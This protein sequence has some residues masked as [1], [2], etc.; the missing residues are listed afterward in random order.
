MLAARRPERPNHVWSYD[1]MQDRTED[2][3]RFRMLTVIDEF[4]RQSLAI[5]VARKLRSD[6][7][8]HCLTDLFVA[9]GTPEHI[10][11]DNVLRQEVWHLERQQI[12]L[13][14]S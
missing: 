3:R 5:V 13:R 6:D 10:R 14:R 7:V 4:T 8:L 9:H 1:F 11:S 12:S 2:G